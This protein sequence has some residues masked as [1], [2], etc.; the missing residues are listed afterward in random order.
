MPQNN[1]SVP[2]NIFLQ[3]NM[4]SSQEYI[5]VNFLKG[6]KKRIIVS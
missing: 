1:V 6:K 3:T 5:E 2:R 4:D